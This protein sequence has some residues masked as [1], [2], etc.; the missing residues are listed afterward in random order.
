M[1]TNPRLAAG[2]L[3]LLAL[4]VLVGCGGSGPVATTTAPSATA[5]RWY[6]DS[7]RPASAAELE[8]LRLTNVHRAAGTR[9]G[10]VSFPAVPALSWDDRL[11]H[12]ARNHSLDMGRSGYFAHTTP[13]QIDPGTRLTDAGYSYAVYG[14]NIAAGQLTP[15]EVVEGWVRSE[16]HCHNL[17]SAAVTQLGVGA[18]VVPGS[19]FETYWTQD[20]GRQR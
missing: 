12:A 18:G 14:E 2:P 13:Q 10:A 9:C 6:P 20:F 8:V 15:A 17:M 16:G 19:S 7:S 3:A 1:F 5:Y 11:A 4:A